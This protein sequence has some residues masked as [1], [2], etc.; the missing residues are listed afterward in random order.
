MKQ[1]RSHPF[2]ALGFRPFYLFACTFALL[3]V[4]LWI[5]QRQGWLVWNGYLDGLT[6]HAHELIFGFASAVISGFLLTAVRNWTQRPTPTGSWL[7][8]LALLW[9]AGRVLCVTGPGVVALLVDVAFLPCLGVAI[10]VPLLRSANRNRF[11]LVVIGVLT[12]VNLAMHLEQLGMAGL[13]RFASV[14]VAFDVLALLMAM[15]AGRV[16]PVFLANAVPQANPQKRGWVEVAAVGGLIVILAGDASG[17]AG[18]LAAPVVAGVCLLTALAHVVR[19]GLWSPRATLREPLLWILPL[20]YAWIPLWL[21]LRAAAAY[22][23][24][25][26]AIVH[27]AL[28]I[29]AMASLMLGM[30]T[31][32]ALGHTGRPLRAGLAEAG[33]FVLIQLS[34]V[35][36]VVPLLAFPGF[37][38]AGVIASAVCWTAAFAMVLGKY[39]PILWRPRIDGR[40]G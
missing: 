15:I 21:L 29:G 9:I 12:L 14:N 25:P 4:P 20:A 13:A 37:Y 10:G 28:A 31:R 17:A 16:T 38:G 19:V 3:S 32:S 5:A 24:V 2:L 27:H 6:W 8:A 40:P 18:S 39:A 23:W 7:A 36:R 26:E 33:A 11:V 34:A 22:A 1:Q 30:M 35:L